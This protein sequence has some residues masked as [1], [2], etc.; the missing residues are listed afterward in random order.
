MTNGSLPI[1]VVGGSGLYELDLLES[2]EELRIDTPFGAPSDALV[3]GTM[4]GREVVFLSR[5]G[6]GHVHTPSEVPYAANIWAL[7]SLGVR[8]V[9]SVS[10][11]GSLR[12]DYIPGQLVVPDQI[13]DRT[14]G[15]RRSTFFGDGVVAHV[16]FAD[17]YCPRL[18]A[19]LLDAAAEAGSPAHPAGTYVCMEGPQFS[20]RA[21]SHLYREWGM[22]IIGMTGLP[23]A[24]L[25]REAELCYA[26]LALVT[27]YDCWREDETAVDALTVAEVM[28]NNVA[29]ARLVLEAA[30]A[31]DPGKP[32]E[33]TCTCADALA[34]AVITDPAA[35]T[36]QAR[37]RLCLLLDGGAGAAG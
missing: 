9:V 4:A 12:E 21:E 29:T 15:T 13:F 20:T 30:L 18:R 32:R 3:R 23:E 5:H 10:A 36:P 33:T 11:V 1:A 2:A 22:D 34:N 28:A 27:D 16:S 35:I 26:T 24:K 31:P 17:P 6:R 37:E 7:K 8:E 19:E 14:R 25:A